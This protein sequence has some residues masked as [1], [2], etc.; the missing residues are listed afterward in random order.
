MKR[1]TRSMRAS[2]IRHP[3]IPCPAIMAERAA[4]HR[5]NL[6]WDSPDKAIWDQAAAAYWRAYYSRTPMCPVRYERRNPTQRCLECGAV[7]QYER[8]VPAWVA[9]RAEGDPDDEREAYCETVDDTATIRCNACGAD[10][11]F[12]ETTRPAA[13]LPDW[14]VDLT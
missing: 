2:G 8:L 10:D 5:M 3:G 4:S 11:N 1:L 7:N 13:A 14:S 9:L 6:R 12:E